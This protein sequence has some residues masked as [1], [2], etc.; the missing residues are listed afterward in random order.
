MKMRFLTLPILFLTLCAGTLNAQ[1]AFNM[2]QFV[3]ADDAYAKVTVPASVWAEMVKSSQEG[4]NQQEACVLSSTPG[5]LSG[6]QADYDG[7][8]TEEMWLLYRNNS[9]EP[10]CNMLAVMT[11]VGGG[12]YKLLD[13]LA[14]PA[15]TALI[16]PIKTLDE[17]V[18]LYAQCSYTLEDG[19][20]ET[21]GILLG[22]RQQSIVILIS[23]TQ[24]TSTVEN[25]RIVQDVQA[26]FVD[27]NYNNRKELF[28]DFR[29]HEPKGNSALSE[30]NMT[31]RYVITLDYLPNH[32]RYGVYDST[33]YDKIQQAG[34]LVKS[35]ERMLGKASTRDEGVVRIREALRLNPFLTRTRVKLGQFFLNQGK[36]ADAEKTLLLARAFD[37]TYPKN[38]KLLGDTYLRL[39]DMQ[40]ALDCYTTYLDMIPKN[41]RTLDARQARIN[42]QRITVWRKKQ[43]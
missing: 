33:G 35:G 37:D 26:A 5:E 22:F 2:K 17:G 19:S 8:G 18:Q 34:S 27:I 32:L 1:F 13:M 12:S 14:L 3:E 25:R 10:G 21:K 6:Y 31:D 16:R 23:W 15:G 42:V 36:Y 7:D 30:K 40:K 9:V 24:K 29:T 43:Y 39:N 41:T 28:L 4:I 11:P 20:P 38:H